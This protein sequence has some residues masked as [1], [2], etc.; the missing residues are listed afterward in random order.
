MGHGGAGQFIYENA[1]S[2]NLKPKAWRYTRITDHKKD[3]R[4]WAS[5]SLV[6][7]PLGDGQKPELKT[8]AQVEETVGGEANITI[9]GHCISRETKRVSI[10]P[11][12]PQVSWVPGMKENEDGSSFFSG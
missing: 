3:T 11:G 4:K 2:E 12:D 6:L 1:V 5:G 7:G 8:C 10:S 9:Y